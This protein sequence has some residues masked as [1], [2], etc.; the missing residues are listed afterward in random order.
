MAVT[1]DVDIAILGGGI[2]GLWLLNRLQSMGYNCLLLERDTLG[3]GQSIASQGMIHGG[4]KYALGGA[5]TGASEAI[6]DMPN[7]WRRCLRGEG[8]VDLRGASVLSEHFFLWSTA[9][10]SSRLT[11]FFAS[12]LTRGRVEPV[13]SAQRPDIFSSPAFRGQL[14]RLTD[15]VLDVPSVIQTLANQHAQRIRR[16]DWPQSHFERRADA[17]SALHLSTPQGPLAVRAQRY[18]LAAGSGNAEL[19]TAMGADRPAMQLRPLH[20][21]LV[22]HDYPAPLYAHCMG[23]N[24]SPRLTVSSHRSTDGRW[25]WYLGGDLATQGVELEPP[26]LIA[27]AQQEL[28]TLFPWIE[29]GHTDWATLRINRAEPRQ[30]GLVKPDQAFVGRARGISNVFA[31]WPTKLTLAPDLAN[32][33]LTAL[34]EDRIVPSR[35]PLPTA[36]SALPQPVMARPSWET[37]FA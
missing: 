37:L 32:T 31:A 30:Q 2:A 8:D 4:I 22:R 10:L 25:V 6:G 29:F 19:L 26:Q 11:T 1:V 33:V 13:A 7:H 17:I 34:D 18:I 36:L 23:S 15:L 21:V 28:D 3:G 24:P 12:R 35:K 5:L 9:A 20:Q 27:R 14:Y 16:I